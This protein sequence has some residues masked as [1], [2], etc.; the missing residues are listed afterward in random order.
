MKKRILAMALSLAMVFTM[1]PAIPARAAESG[2]GT[3]L[4]LTAKASSV[5]ENTPAASVNDG[6]L[7]TGDPATSWNSWNG[8]ESDYPMP[9]TLTW[10][11]AQTLASM[12]V[13]WWS[14]GG[15]VTWPSNA[16]VQYLDGSEWKDIADAGI[17][18]GGYNGADGVWNIVNFGNTVTTTS[19]RMLV[20]R[21]VQGT[22]GVGISEWEVYGTPL[23][24]SISDVKIAGSSK[25]MVGEK[26][27]YDGTTVPG[28]LAESASYG[29]SVEP[30]N[31]AEID[32]AANKAT[33]SVKGLKYGD[34]T[35]KLK[36]THEGVS[37]E[38]S[39]ALRVRAEGI[40]SIDIYK[41]STA[42]G[43]APILPDSVVANGLEFDD[44]TPDL[45]AKNYNLAEEFN[46]SLVPV[47]WDEVP[48]AKYAAE[49]A[50]TSF[51]VK[52]IVNYDDRKYV[53][54]A[55]VTVREAVEAPE[56]NSSVTF[57][58]VQLNDTFWA[59]KQQ[60]NAIN[61][62]NK[63]ILEIGKPS[64]GEPN[65][66]NAIKKLNG[67]KNYGSFSGYVFQDSDIYKSI[68]AIS[69]TLSAT[70]NDTSA[71]MTAQR[72]VLEDTL[73][74]WIGK[75]EKVQYADGYI[76][77][78]FTLRSQSSSGGGS[79]GT[80]RWRNFANHEMYNAGHFL[81][82]VVA[83]TRYRE[84]IGKPDYRL[85]VA[86]KR[87]A[88]HIV[89]MF[90]PNGKRHEVPGHEEIELAMV[91]FGKLVEE[92]EGKGT[93]QDYYDTIKVLID[94][95]GESASLRESGYK[96]NEYSQDRTPFKDETN[97]VGHS[98]RA[99]YFYTGVTDI[100]TMLPDGNADRDDY[101][102]SLDTIWNSV[103]ERKTYITGAVGAATATSSSE[104]FGADYDL[105]PAQ[106]YA[107]ICA[108]I[109]VANWNQRMNLLHEDGK[110]ADMVEK[111]LYN[112]ILVGTNLDGNRFYYSTQLRV[113]GGNGRSEWFG[114]ACC[115]PNLMRTIAAASGYM[116]NVHGDDVFVNMYAGSEGK[117]HV[118]GTEVGLTQTTNY[119][120][121][122]TVDL[123]VSPAAAK[124]FT[125]KIRIPGWVNEQQNKNVTIKVG[126]E[127]V[128]APAEK[129]YVA[130]TRTWNKGDVVHIDMPME[131]RKTES[132]PNVVPTQGQ[133]A[134]QRGP[135]VYCMEKAGNAQL[136]PEIAN[137]DPLNFVI[138]RDAELTATYNENLLKGVVEITGNVKY[139]NGSSL[140]DAKLQAVPY[141]AWNNRSDDADYTEGTIKNRSTKML[142]WTTAA[143][144]SGSQDPD[145][146]KEPEVPYVPVPQLR[147]FA[148][149]SVSYVGW[150]A[151]ADRFADDEMSTFW[152]GHSDPNDLTKPENYQWMQ[153]DFGS[154]KAK[155]SGAQITFYDDHSG[156]IYPSGMTIEY[157]DAD[158]NMQQVEPTNDWA[159]TQVNDIT[160]ESKPTF[161]EIET[162]LIKVTLHNRNGVA[163][164]VYD[165]KLTGDI[166]ADDA[167]KTEINNKI[168]EVEAG[169]AQLNQNDYTPESWEDVQAALTD[170][171]AV[172]GSENIT[173]IAAAEKEK[174]LVT[175]FALLDKKA[176]QAKID[177]LQADITKYESEKDT[178]SAA[179]WAEFEPVLNEAKEALN[180]A[181]TNAINAARRK[182]RTAAEKL[183]LSA[184][185]AIQALRDAVA[186]YSE[187]EYT[188]ASW[189]K[190]AAAFKQANDVLGS[191]NPGLQVVNNARNALETA[192]SKLDKKA[193]AGTVDAL[194]GT[195]AG[196]VEAEY[197]AES[198]KRFV[199]TLN[200]VSAIANK[201]DPGQKEL[202]A[203]AASLA[204]AAEKL[205][206]KAGAD[207]I[208]KL[209]A[210]IDKV[211]KS[212]NQT[213]YTTTSW[214]E[215]EGTLERL[216]LEA[217]GE[218]ASASE[219][220]A[221]AEA[222]NDAKA[223]LELRASASEISAFKT[224][225]NKYKTD[226][227][228]EDYTEESY[229]AME[230]AIKRAEQ[231]AGYAAEAIGKSMIETAMNRMADAV[232][233][234][235][236][237]VDKTALNAAIQ[238]AEGKKEAD[239]TAD[240]Y[241]KLAEALK[242]A[243][244]VA[245]KADATQGEVDS[246]KTELDDAIKGLQEKP[247]V[248][249][250]DKKALNA[251]I[252]TAEG[253]KQASFTS[254]SFS[255]LKKALQAA[256]KVAAK[257]D[258]TQAEVNSVKKALDTA[259]K[260][261]VKL[262][263]KS[264]TLVVGETFSVAGKGC[265]YATSNKANASVTKKGVVKAL[266]GGKTV[267]IK[268]TNKSKKTEVQYK[269]TIRKAPSKISKVTIKVKGQKKASNIA[270]KKNK[271][272]VSLKKGK[273]AT[274][275][276]T[277]PKKTYSKFKYTL[278]SSKYKKLA[279]V[280]SKG[281]IKTKKKGTVR[282]KIQT[283]N[284]KSVIITVKIK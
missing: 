129:G 237:I 276:P 167:L 272:T 231:I 141:Y 109:A 90:G 37:K 177:Q 168:A 173:A 10:D 164:A 133:I 144:A 243:K 258:A 5:R 79:P 201:E 196:Y 39:L 246:A 94:R 242:K 118:G 128:T 279:T 104:G 162:S 59:P 20:G 182:L 119:P 205:A 61:S 2:L 278:T 176:D 76:D 219:V 165:W 84:G 21:N 256:K 113:N 209:A 179:S 124:A 115:P 140:I 180:S 19:L 160:Y 103:T 100:A 30:A 87:F 223:A 101:L 235:E 28:T 239:Y 232:D 33:V 172:M 282:I 12:R 1:L 184:G 95:R 191:E 17:E 199:Y 16:K 263:K 270:L 142:I 93:A 68:E 25:L 271:G 171:K 105:P 215:F 158:G 197:T 188:A 4:A 60:T 41:T 248:V 283:L 244:D 85:Y 83:Y 203:A 44:P 146:D 214:Q 178:Y 175:A 116:Y 51:T 55:V 228:K 150:G 102:N 108:A 159:I 56:S 267:T 46:A 249:T 148:T 216:Q 127:E 233:S 72:K 131:I 114:C 170:M 253:K 121:E 77:T 260:N 240:S 52:G 42:A 252:K 220:I 163:V 7:A 281:V 75:I 169:M 130:I 238:E 157:K 82:G 155:I 62:L 210:E 208:S 143:N 174:A 241:S 57:E 134:L 236:R 247:P 27:Q 211:K 11:S 92:Y 137:F 98:V 24:E 212:C 269:V 64:G 234:L 36:A 23:K 47:V 117:V 251:S 120:W 152:N 198:W 78:F 26:Q 14:D 86:G 193:A 266:K 262:T 110:Y 111:N 3:N 53:A 58:N 217:E 156:V 66:D 71:A 63:A 91:K 202:N 265:T 189:A 154:R 99:G 69:Y 213:E 89:M 34:A 48:A 135:I 259:V 218:G 245:A 123:A 183:D 147:H 6:K 222:A 275:T 35:L 250:V 96:G 181:G 221:L 106:S 107:E 151:G 136:N 206:K 274:L 229:S 112:S 50:G 192:A 54:T 225:L 22:T 226:Y 204:T 277:L 227:P 73:E 138:P 280:S 8:N 139:Q 257:S 70:Q 49:K 166:A 230:K 149:P 195:I 255:K 224:A 18:H 145:D 15:G 186:K 125:L 254:D 65:Y 126:Q 32:G 13:M 29:W 161:K 190:F 284:N 273:T 67:E 31:I 40:Q 207:A 122:G 97:A 81:E 88:D 45:M 80:H 38:T 132:D 261:L 268:V 43:V 9:I 187:A 153:Y 74:R 264:K 194:K 200:E 185:E